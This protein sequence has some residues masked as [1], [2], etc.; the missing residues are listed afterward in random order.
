MGRRVAKESIALEDF[1]AS[2]EGIWT[3]CVHASTLDES[4]MAY[5][6]FESIEAQLT[7]TVEVLER[8]KPLYN[9]KASE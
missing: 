8:V 2:M 4:P 3:S 7:D 1:K 5:K 6:D 9:F